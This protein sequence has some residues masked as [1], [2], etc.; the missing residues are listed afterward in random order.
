MAP[1]SEM[2]SGTRSALAFGEAVGDARRAGG[3][4]PSA[5]VARPPR[6]RV[7]RGARRGVGL[8]DRGLG[9]LADHLLGGR[10]DDR[11]GARRRRRPTRRRSAACTA[12]SHSLMLARSRSC[13]PPVGTP[14]R[15]PRLQS[16]GS[17]DLSRRIGG[18]DARRRHQGRHGHRRHRRAR[19]RRRRRHPRRPHRRRRRAS[20][21]RPS[22][23]IDAAGLVVT[24]GFVDPHTHYDAQLLLG[25]DAPARRTSTAS[26]RDRRQ[27]RLHAR[28]RSAPATPTT[29]AG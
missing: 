8:R 22:E 2:I 13:S 12:S 25:P 19:R 24:P 15:T 11:R 7:L 1:V 21:S 9:R 28:A 4:A 29:C 23:T 6:E 20:T 17:S 5:G 27:L 16:D 14:S 18:A 26:R 10:V 3:P